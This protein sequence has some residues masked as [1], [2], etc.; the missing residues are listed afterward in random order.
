MDVIVQDNQRG[1]LFDNGRYIKMLEPGKYSFWFAANK[2]VVLV[3]INQG[4]YVAGYALELFLQKDGG[5]NKYLDVVDVADNEIVLQYADGKLERVLPSGKKYAFW[6]VLKK[7]TF[8]H[9][10]VSSPDTSKF[11]NKSLLVKPPLSSYTQV[12]A[13][14]PSMQGLLLF[15]N[16]LQKI[17]PAGNYVFWK[18][19]TKVEVIYVDMRQKDVEISG[20]DIMTEDKVP[21]RMNFVCQYVVKDAKKAA[22]EFKDYDKQIYVF[23]QML[24]REYVGTLK[25]DDLLQTKR[26]VADYILKAAKAKSCEYGVEFL[27]AGVKDIIMP[28]EIREILNTVLIAEKKAMANVITRREETASTRSLLNTAKLMD[29]NKT[30]Y[31]LKELE[32]LEKICDNVGNISLSSKDSLIDSLNSILKGN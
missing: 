32:F 24:L 6:N 23:L 12:F 18:C 8:E 15:D 16:E 19:S 11:A 4:F 3:D 25:L 9:I 5:L 21:V 1:L 13:V 27:Y 26:E 10:D 29:E 17:L 28:G 2:N 7:N 14:P 31:R 30:L 20:Q 22:L